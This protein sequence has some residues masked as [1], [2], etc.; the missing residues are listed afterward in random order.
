VSGRPKA[1]GESGDEQGDLDAIPTQWSLLSL[2]H[3][4][5]VTVA[6]EARDALAL[7]YCKAI[8]NFAHVL[9]H[10]EA[11][12]DD[13]AQDVLRRL[14]AGDFARADPGRGR[15]RDLLKTAMRNMTRTD[16]RRG[17]RFRNLLDAAM[18]N[19]VPARWASRQGPAQSAP[20]D[21]EELDAAWR[22]SLLDMTLSALDEHQRTHSGNIFG[23]LMRLRIANPEDDAEQ[24]AARLAEA[25]G[26][27]LR[28]DALRQQLR[29]ARLRFGQ[30]LLEEL[31]RSMNDPTPQRVEEELC[32]TG[33]MEYVRDLLPA[34]WRTR[35]MLQE[36]S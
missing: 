3:R 9:V 5:S 22:R 31:A 17:R 21:E 36:P 26:R 12:A 2:A 30:L 8:N 1:S 23:T 27:T 20:R 10:D 13:L 6:G 14:L 25:T 15:F 16:A 24:L 29:R 32:E 19:V 33:L 18:R 28:L 11:K 7:R 34:D 35:G 4:H